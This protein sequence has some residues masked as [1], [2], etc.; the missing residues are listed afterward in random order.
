[1][2]SGTKK[3]KEECREVSSIIKAYLEGQLS[4]EQ[5][6]KVS[7]HSEACAACESKMFEAVDELGSP[8]FFRSVSSN[9][10]KPAVHIDTPGMVRR[11][12]WWMVSG[13]LHAAVILMTAIWIVARPE[14]EKIQIFEMNI[15]TYRKPEYEPAAKREIEKNIREIRSEVFTE[16]PVLTKEELA[17]DKLETPDDLDREFTAKGRQEAVSTIELEGDGWIGVFGVGSAGSGAYGWRSG[18][19]KKRAIGRFGGSA[20]TESAVLAALRWLARHQEPG[21]HWDLM[22]Y[23]PGRPMR[24]GGSENYM[25]QADPSISA[26]ALLAFLG[27]GHTTRAGRFRENVQ[28]ALDYLISIQN[29]DGSVGKAQWMTNPGSYNTSIGAL[30]LAE[31]AGMRCGSEAEFAAQKAIDFLCSHQHPNGS[32]GYMR[33]SSIS[34]WVMMALKSGKSAKMK[35]KDGV[36]EKCLEFFDSLTEWPAEDVCYKGIAKVGYK[37]KGNYSFASQGYALTAVGMLM[38]QYMGREQDDPKLKAMANYLMT[39]LPEWKFTYN[40]STDR[41]NF[42]YWYYGTLALFQMGQ[43]YWNQWNKVM[44]EVLVKNQ[45]KGGPMDGSIKDTDGS[46]DPETVWGAWGGR[47]YSTAVL[48]MCLEVYYRYS[49]LYI[50]KK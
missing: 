13:I 18:G 21:G 27:A 38:H 49:N 46:W 24:Y 34:G 31:A 9:L 35:I 28:K 8:G 48:C 12:P 33:G 17:I 6:K 16:E 1:M 4:E 45:C 29:D 15:K 32:F 25:K 19:G 36:M 50:F 41:Q 14:R 20:A 30:A 39:L 11:T 7:T 37:R 10:R 47:V 5:E 44:K 43:D 42:Y 3:M 23:V 22:K 40:S 26:L 2:V